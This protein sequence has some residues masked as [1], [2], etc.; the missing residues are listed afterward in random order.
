MRHIGSRLE[1]FVD[2]YLIERL[3]GVS[4]RLHEPQAQEV[5]FSFDAPWEGSGS[6]YV[7]V[8]EDEGHYRMYYRGSGD[9]PDGTPG[10]R[11]CMATSDNGIVWTRPN[12]R[13]F[14]IQ[15]SKEN[16]IIWME[17]PATH[18]FAPFRDTHP[19][20]PPYEQ[21]KAVAY[22]ALSKKHRALA[23]FVSPDGVHWTKMEGGEQLIT[24]GAFDSLNV[25]FWDELADHYVCYLRDFDGR[26]RAIRRAVSEDFRTWSKPEW[27]QYGDAPIEQFYTN[28]V[29]PYPRAPH[30]HLSFPKRFVPERHLIK[31]HK[32]PGV[33]D[34]VFMSS[35]D[36]LHW[37]RT[38]LEAFVR[39]GRDPNNWTQRSNM[40]AWGILRTAEDELSM[41][42][43]EHY[44]HPTNRLRR[45]TLRLDGFASVHADGR[46]GE[47]IT[48]PLIFE[49]TELVLNVATS[50]AGGVAVEIQDEGGQPLP[51]YALSECPPFY[52]DEI[53]CVVGWKEDS[54]VSRLAG[55]PIRL[56]FAMKD[57]DLYSIRFRNHE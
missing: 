32:H 5:V 33:S 7:T 29:I 40:A 41:Y 45:R 6:A 19:A 11:T 20:C 12:L 34:G 55:R 35:R 54:D 10:E 4:L 15:G 36:G 56:R 39:P 37:D 52:G 42:Y 50:A 48:K 27:F 22:G 1:L 14:E 46:G 38:F 18:N 26:V 23:G 17:S 25:A 2:Y 53:E 49:G 31:E 9:V 44:S 8:F 3:D 21:Y 57:A 13:L 16:N 51:G 43:S 30:I 24:E 28:A 47:L